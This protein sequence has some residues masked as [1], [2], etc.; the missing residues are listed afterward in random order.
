LFHLLVFHSYSTTFKAFQQQSQL[1]IEH[2][3]E[4]QFF[5]D[6]LDVPE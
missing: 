4:L 5:Q 3:K 6:R 2:S 1:A